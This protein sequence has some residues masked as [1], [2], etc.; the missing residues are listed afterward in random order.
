MKN[1]ETEISN[2]EI[3]NQRFVDVLLLI[4]HLEQSLLAVDSLGIQSSNA[5]QVA[6]SGQSRKLIESLASQILLLSE[7]LQTHFAEPK[8][9]R[10]NIL[11]LGNYYVSLLATQNLALMLSNLQEL[12]Y[13]IQELKEALQAR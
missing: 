11:L 9:L 12:K 6:L 8:T 7:I 3:I 10:L 13:H 2:G 1:L 5:V 4:K